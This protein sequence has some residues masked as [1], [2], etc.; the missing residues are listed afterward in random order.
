[1]TVRRLAAYTAIDTER[2]YQEAQQGN[3]RKSNERLGEMQ[4]IT[5]TNGKCLTL[6]EGIL[7]MEKLLDDAR[8]HWYS[9]DGYNEALHHVRKVAGVATQLMENFGAPPRGATA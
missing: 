8:G 3:S 1:M 2:D 4:T 6:G 7:V 5:E 9:P